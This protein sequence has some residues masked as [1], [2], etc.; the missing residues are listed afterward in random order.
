MQT[1][2]LTILVLGVLVFV[3]ELGH[4]L[5]AKWAGIGVP[6]FSIGLGPRVVGVKVGET[7]YCLSAI[8]FG[9]YV[10]MAG[11][12]GEEAFEGLEG[13]GEDAAF[14]PEKRFEG[15]T[16]GQRLVVISA[17]VAMNF[18]LGWGIY[19]GLAWKNGI[20]TVDGTVVAEVDSAALREHP[21][22]AE[23]EGAAIG[24]VD[25]RPVANWYEIGEA[26][27]DGEGPV[28]FGLATGGAVRVPLDED[29]DRDEVMAGLVPL[30]PSIVA[31]VEPDGPAARAGLRAGDRIV[32]IDGIP[33]ESFLEVSEVVRSRPDRVVPVVV[34]RQG[35]GEPSRLSFAVRTGATRAPRPGD[36]RF[37][38]V[39]WLGVSTQI[40]E[41]EL[42]PL[43]AIAA[44]SGAA[45]RASTLIL[46]GLFQLV[47]GQVSLRSLG[48]PVAIGQITGLAARQGVGSLLAWVALFS[49]NLA[50]L[51]LLPIPVL[52]GGHIL[53]LAIEGTRGRPL[54]AR[55]KM[56]LSQVGLAF[57]VLLM[58]WAFTA[59]ILRLLGF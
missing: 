24:T 19:V 56:R 21:A 55:Q 23:L 3:H 44:G 31:E 48:G 28:D 40:D 18:L 47:T 22:L 29:E 43:E 14:P 54:S 2:L 13:G 7:D 39:G 57:L 42:G 41:I 33:T 25:G 35:A 59:D 53:F 8:P 27:A 6:R 46:T 36:G 49:I 52:D 17:G 45:V 5:T 4:F 1:L 58:A 15:K 26:L 34:E 20:P 10:K 32:S 38:D 50:I 51:N 9:G 16:I 37:I 30:V 12:E 11:M